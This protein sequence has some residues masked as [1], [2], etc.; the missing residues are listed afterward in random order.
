M[1]DYAYAV[2]TKVEKSGGAVVINQDNSVSILMDGKIQEVIA[3]DDRKLNSGEIKK[4]DQ[5]R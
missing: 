2:S 5:P 4:N 3:V 1:K